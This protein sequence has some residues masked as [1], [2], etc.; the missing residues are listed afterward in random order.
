MIINSD[1]TVGFTPNTGFI[2]EATITYEITDGNGGT[3]TASVTVSVTLDG[4]ATKGP[5]DSALVF[6]DRD[7]DDVL[8][9]DEAFT[10]TADDGSYSLDLKGKTDNTSSDESN[11]PNL[12][13]RSVSSMTDEE[14]KI[15]NLDSTIRTVDTITGNV[16]DNII[17]RATSDATVISPLTTLAVA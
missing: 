3:A 16:V 7:G 14:L 17:M 1:N 13:A 6:F 9:S 4:V 2:G 10:I 15:A 5:L 11:T 8:D 12:V